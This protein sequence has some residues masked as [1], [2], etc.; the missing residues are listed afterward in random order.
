MN[1]GASIRYVDIVKPIML[2]ESQLRIN[3][4]NNIPMEAVETSPDQ[5]AKVKKH[6]IPGIAA[7]SGAR[8][9]PKAYD[10]G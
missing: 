9:T 10:A 3:T 2:M 4:T 7:I 1:G 8:A 6:N 5:I